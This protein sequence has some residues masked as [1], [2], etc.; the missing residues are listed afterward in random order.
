ME[1]PEGRGAL[2]DDRAAAEGREVLRTE[3]PRIYLAS[4]SDY[5]A[6]ILH[7]EWIDANQAPEELHA[8]AAA[9]LARS[10]SDPRAEEFAIHDF[11]NFGRYR[12]GEYD[13]L[14]WVSRV[15]RGIDEHG[16]AFAAWAELSD[17]DHET[18]DRFDDAYLGERDSLEAYAEE[19]LT[20]LGYV[21]TIERAVPETLQPYVSIDFA[22]FADELRSNGSLTVIENDRGGVWVFEESI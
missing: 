15:A 2:P 13:S 16:P 8:A 9:M 18:L 19:L 1:T 17:H 20:D 3:T 7:G 10:P 21:E 12:V 14:D 5:N 22:A 4:L 6:G 11:D